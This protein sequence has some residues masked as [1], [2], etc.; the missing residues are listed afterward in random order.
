MIKCEHRAKWLDGYRWSKVI[1]SHCF[2]VCGLR[3]P[4]KAA[5]IIQTEKIHEPGVRWGEQARVEG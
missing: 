4:D 1:E 3:P 2:Y 5:E